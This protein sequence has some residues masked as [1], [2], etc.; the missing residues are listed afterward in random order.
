MVYTEP[1]RF[2]YNDF[3][4]NKE[5]TLHAMLYQFEQAGSHHSEFVGDTMDQQIDRGITWI[6][7]SWRVHVTRRPV[8]GEPISV[9]TWIHQQKNGGL[10]MTRCFS[11]TNDKGEEL[12][13]A[14]GAYGLYD[15]NNQTLVKMSP[16][17]FN[18]YEP[19]E[20]A[21]YKRR[22]PRIRLPETM[23][24]IFPFSLRRS[25]M[26]YNGHVH[27][28]YYLSFALEAVSREDYWN[29]AIRDVS[30]IYKLPL[31]EGDPVEIQSHYDPET[32]TYSIGIYGRDHE[33]S[34][35]AE[36]KK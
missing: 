3:N 10:L 19:E 8:Y 31:K 34:F 24:T 32:Q 20:R 6:I 2:Q 22:L 15:F 25:D 16:E 14:D 13:T 4:G 21:L 1:C 9:N 23:E 7:T 27:N 29:E 5:L 18:L 28:T 17:L 36:L 11:L 30:I 33:L 26:D 35:L 12:V